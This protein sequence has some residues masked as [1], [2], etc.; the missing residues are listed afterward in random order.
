MRLRR[1]VRISRPTEVNVN[2]DELQ[3][4]CGKTV[5]SV[6]FNNAH[7]LSIRFTDATV[8]KVCARFMHVPTVTSTTLNAKAFLEVEEVKT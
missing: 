5:E 4:I 1:L 6:I 8:I 2:D 3:I 7:Y